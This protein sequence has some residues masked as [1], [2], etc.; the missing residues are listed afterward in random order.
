MFAMLASPSAPT[1]REC[2]C[3]STHA[4][5]LKVGAQDA[6]AMVI[7]SLLDES[8]TS[9]TCVDSLCAWL[10]IFYGDLNGSFCTTWVTRCLPAYSFIGCIVFVSCGQCPSCEGPSI[11]CSLPVHHHWLVPS[12]VLRSSAV[13]QLQVHPGNWRHWGQALI[14]P[15]LCSYSSL[16]WLFAALSFP[17]NVWTI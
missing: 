17:P 2:G 7:F 10:H 1:N 3:L 9:L 16:K 13:G 6:P 8:M 5:L 11:P 15:Y 14:S 4:K 12:L